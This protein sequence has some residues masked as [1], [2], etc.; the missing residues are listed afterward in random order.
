MPKEYFHGLTTQDAKEERCV[1]RGKLL[2]WALILGMVLAAALYPALASAYEVFRSIDNTGRP[3]ALKLHDKPCTNAKVQAKLYERLL[4]DRRF[5]AATLTYQ[6]RD[7]ASCWV[8]RQGT[9]LSIDEEGAPFQPVP[10]H[11]FR[12]E[13]I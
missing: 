9:V 1:L 5:K 12:D 13:S 10:R 2:F 7:W 6:G 11:L 4:D 3:A 8:E